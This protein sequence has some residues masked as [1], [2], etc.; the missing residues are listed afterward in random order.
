VFQDISRERRNKEFISLKGAI[1]KKPLS[2]INEGF[3]EE[4]RFTF[5]ELQR[6]KRH[7]VED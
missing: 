2:T 3:P 5:A 1:G 7:G 6:Q 4:A